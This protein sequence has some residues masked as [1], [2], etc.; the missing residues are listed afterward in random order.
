MSHKGETRNC[1]DI[2]IYNIFTFQVAMDIM[3]NDEYQEPQ[4]MNECW[5][6]ND[7]PKWKEA[8]QIELNSL[9]KWEVF[10]PVV[11]T[12]ENIKLVGYKWVFV[13]KRNKN[14]EI[15][16]YKARGNLFPYNGCNHISILNKFNSLLKD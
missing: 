8:I 6:M 12:P 3:R 11:Q 2:I 13:R 4:T 15:I 7:W 10:G 9:T 5:K 16:R 1:C 14:D